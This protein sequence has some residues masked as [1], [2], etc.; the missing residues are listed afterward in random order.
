MSEWRGDSAPWI[1][2]DHSDTAQMGVWLH[3][4]IIDF[5]N[6]VKPREFEGFIRGKL[7][8]DLRE[9]VRKHFAKDKADILTFGSYPAGL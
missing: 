8:E 6:Y 4:E 2:I 7:V 1:N 5:Y 9:R 3:K